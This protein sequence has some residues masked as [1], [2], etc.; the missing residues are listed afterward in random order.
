MIKLFLESESENEAATTSTSKVSDTQDEVKTEDDKKLI[1]PKTKKLIKSSAD[2]DD[3]DWTKIVKNEDMEEERQEIQKEKK[4]IRKQ[5]TK[6]IKK[7]MVPRKDKLEDLDVSLYC[8][9]IYFIPFSSVQCFFASV[10][11][12]LRKN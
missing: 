2:S 4:K 11:V 7:C 12:R 6:K 3:D 5:R 1:K 8:N 10:L 9:L